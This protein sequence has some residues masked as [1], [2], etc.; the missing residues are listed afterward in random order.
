MND[1]RYFIINLDDE[2]LE[3]IINVSLGSLEE[4][5][6]NIAETKIVIKLCC[7]DTNNYPFLSQY[8]EYSKQGIIEALDN[9]EWRRPTTSP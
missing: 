7:G 5:R 6:K 3:Q 4:Q 9:D 8:E 2:N 1:N